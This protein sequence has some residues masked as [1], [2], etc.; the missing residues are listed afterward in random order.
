MYI[1]DIISSAI[2]THITFK[3][4]TLKL[5]Y[6]KQFVTMNMVSTQ[7]FTTIIF[8]ELRCDLGMQYYFFCDILL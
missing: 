7:F 3:R 4:I 1:H 5:W 8:E 6:K 2:C